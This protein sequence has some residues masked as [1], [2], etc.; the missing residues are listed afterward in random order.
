MSSSRGAGRSS[1][2]PGVPP[3]FS[4]LLCTD[5]CSSA[6]LPQA[7]KTSLGTAKKEVMCLTHCSLDTCLYLLP[8]GFR[9]GTT[10]AQQHYRTRSDERVERYFMNKDALCTCK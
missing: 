3:P 4:N 10:I 9:E 1:A 7:D 5:R 2:S 6:R 8:F